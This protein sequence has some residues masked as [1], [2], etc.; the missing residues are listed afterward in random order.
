M[1]E[2]QESHQTLC[3]FRIKCV[4]AAMWGTLSVQRVRLMFGFARKW[5]PMSA[6]RGADLLWCCGCV[7]SSI[8]LCSWASQFV[9]EWLHQGCDGDFA[10][11]FFSILALTIFLL[12]FIQRSVSKSSFFGFG[13]EIRF[14]SCNFCCRCVCESLLCVEVSLCKN[15]LG[16]KAI[17]VKTCLCKS[18]FV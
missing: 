12:K 9:L 6:L 5:A 15:L 14:R 2:G 11:F 8:V 10:A 1:L 16:V 7:C 13:A 18:L 4:S 3:F 17:C